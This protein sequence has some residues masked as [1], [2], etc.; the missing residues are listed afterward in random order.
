MKKPSPQNGLG[1][2]LM[3]MKRLPD[4]LMPMTYY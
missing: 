2:F 1:S 4:G 3:S